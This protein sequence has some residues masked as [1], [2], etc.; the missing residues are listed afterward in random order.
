MRKSL[1]ILTMAL[2][3]LSGNALAQGS[4]AY[5]ATAGTAA[6]APA[7]PRHF[8]VVTVHVDGATGITASA[9]HPAEA[10]PTQPFP[11]GGGLLLRPLSAE[12]N[13]SVRAFVFQ[14][15]QIIVPAGTPVTLSFVGVQGPSFNIAVD[16]VAEPIALRRGE[17][18]S[19]AVQAD[20]PGIIGFR[21]L[22]QAPSMTGQILVLPR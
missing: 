4:P 19:V 3:A 18:H 9:A 11:A 22:G 20:R 15:S 12:G 14:P 10:Y 2:A 17:V 6:T 1:T 8:H 13:W 21:A 5:P 16:G 7:D